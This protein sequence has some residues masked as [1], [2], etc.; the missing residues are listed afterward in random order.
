MGI[1]TIFKKIVKTIR[2]PNSRSLSSD[3]SHDLVTTLWECDFLTPIKEFLERGNARVLDVATG[4]GTWVL[5]CAEKYPWSNFTGVDA[6]LNFPSV[7]N[8]NLMNATFLQSDVLD[9]LLFDDNTFDFVHIRCITLIFTDQ[10]WENKVLKE[11]IRV[12]KPGGWIELV[13]SD[14]AG[15]IN[16]GPTHAHLCE[17][18]GIFFSG[19]DL[20]TIAGENI[21]YYLKKEGQVTEI[22][23]EIRIVPYYGSR[24]GRAFADHLIKFIHAYKDLLATYMGFDDQGWEDNVKLIKRELSE[25]RTESIMRRVYCKKIDPE[26]DLV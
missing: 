8:I 20:V 3:T 7:A 24:L 10:Q 23:E 4:R 12:C 9:R 19:H 17:T 25:Y 18:A 22:N 6:S 5:E 11:L 16:Q 26:Q 14:H 21:A 13:V 2:F 15:Y 1:F